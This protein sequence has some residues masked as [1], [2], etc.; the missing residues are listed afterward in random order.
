MQSKMNEIAAKALTVPGVD[1]ASVYYLLGLCN[2]KNKNW[3]NALQAYRSALMES[4]CKKQ[5]IDIEENIVRVKLKIQQ[6]SAY[7]YYLQ[8]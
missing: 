5:S 6:S 8:D 1:S 3:T 7:Q 4:T 2:E